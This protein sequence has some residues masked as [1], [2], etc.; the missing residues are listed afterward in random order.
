[1]PLVFVDMPLGSKCSVTMVGVPSLVVVWHNP[2]G[3]PRGGLWYVCYQLLWLWQILGI[4][5][6]RILSVWHSA[7]GRTRILGVGQVFTSDSLCQLAQDVM[8]WEEGMGGQVQPLNNKKTQRAFACV[9]SV[10]LES[11]VWGTL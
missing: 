7:Q 9:L 10:R 5:P 1:M 2:S 4:V 8:L 3:G 11:M 6:S